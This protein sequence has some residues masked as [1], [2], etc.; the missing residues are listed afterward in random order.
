ME[1]VN[2]QAIQRVTPRDRLIQTAMRFFG[3]RGI[4]VPMVEI[5]A[6]AGNRNKS[7]V[8]Y[9]FDGKAGLID[10]VYD[11]IL[12]YLEPRFDLLLNGLETASSKAPRLYDI[13]LSL[14]APFFSLYASQP[15]GDAA[16]KALARLGHD[17]APGQGRM[18]TAFLTET[19]NRFEALICKAA[20]DKS[21]GQ[22]KFHLAHYLMATVNGL[23]VTDRWQEI[24][25]RTDP[26]LMFELL[27]SYTDYV[28]GGITGSEAKRPKIDIGYWRK[29]IQP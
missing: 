10:A 18:Y 24:N 17:S 25:F 7:A 16:L 14:N 21:V 23:A 26:D 19:F 29:A 11:E 5:A 2:F 15:N 20:P 1:D 3:D 6:A 13:A 8:A 9:H 28:A 4:S 27:L 12:S 22:I